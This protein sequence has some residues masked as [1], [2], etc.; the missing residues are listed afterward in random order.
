MLRQR[1]ADAREIAVAEDAPAA[2]EEPL[3]DAIALDVLLPEEP[4]QRLGHREPWHQPPR[5]ILAAVSTA[6]YTLPSGGESSVRPAT[7]PRTCG[8]RMAFSHFAK[9]ASRSL[10]GAPPR[11]TTGSVVAGRSFSC[12]STTGRL[13]HPPA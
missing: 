5:T 13:G 9:G 4:H 6:S 1:L 3:L 10:P 7:S 12:P 2:G 8:S 11:S